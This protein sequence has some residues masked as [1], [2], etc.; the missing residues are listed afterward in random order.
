MLGACRPASAEEIPLGSHGS[1]YSVAVRLND[2]ITLNF[3]LDTGAS[4]VA[5]PG[6][7]VSTRLR[8]GTLTE[9]DFVGSATYLLADGSKLPSLRFILREV[10]VGNQSARNVVANV[11]PVRGEP[12]L[13]QGF[14]S[15]L[16]PWTI[17]YRRHALV[18]IGAT[19][20]PTV[21]ISPHRSRCR[22]AHRFPLW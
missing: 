3:L 8:T 15:R 21:A 10:R 13:G 11:S 5:L 17:D 19:P 4:D 14:L 18:I 1:T 2:A 6:D 20:S 22:P 7:V 12:L 16:P 9:R